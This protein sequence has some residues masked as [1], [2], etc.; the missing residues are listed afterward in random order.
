MP[1]ILETR[2]VKCLQQSLDELPQPAILIGAS[3]PYLKPQKIWKEKYR[4][5]I[6]LF[7]FLFTCDICAIINPCQRRIFRHVNHIGQM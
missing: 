5:A 1:S 3:C 2:N 4:P 6:F 7:V